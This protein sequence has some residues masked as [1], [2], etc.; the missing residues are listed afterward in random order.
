MSPKRVRFAVIMDLEARRTM[1]DDARQRSAAVDL[2]WIPLG[3][4]QHVVRLGGRL[5]GALRSMPAR[6]SRLLAVGHP[7]GARVSSWRPVTLSGME[8]PGGSMSPP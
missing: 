5:F 7:A 8:T 4:G 6:S 2:Y 1:T 3:A